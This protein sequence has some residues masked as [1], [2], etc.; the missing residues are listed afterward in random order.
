MALRYVFDAGAARKIMYDRFLNAL[1][2]VHFSPFTQM[3]KGNAESASI[4]P[5]RKQAKNKAK[6]F[7]IRNKDLQREY[8]QLV[9]SSATG[10][11]VL[12]EV[13]MGVLVAVGRKYPEYMKDIRM[14]F[15]KDLCK[16]HETMP[17]KAMVGRTDDGILMYTRDMRA[18]TE[19]CLASMYIVEDKIGVV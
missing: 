13:L 12:Q 16:W 4:V 10:I 5:F 6:M 15:V 14:M 8:H 7:K 2:E 18:R 1:Y 11:A 3:V 19:K 17:S 9:H